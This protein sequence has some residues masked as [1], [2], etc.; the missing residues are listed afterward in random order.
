MER[1][2]KKIYNKR[3]HSENSLCYAPQISGHAGVKY[4]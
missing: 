3:M 2:L 1:K 4:R